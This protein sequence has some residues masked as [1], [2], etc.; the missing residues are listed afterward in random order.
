MAVAYVV[1]ALWLAVEPYRRPMEPFEKQLVPI[2]LVVMPVLA[3]LAGALSALL[4]STAWWFCWASWNPRVS[5]L[6]ATFPA[7]DLDQ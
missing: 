7:S 6:P 2:L 5:D 4:L 1:L 3:I